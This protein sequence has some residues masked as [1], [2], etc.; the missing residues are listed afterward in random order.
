M[1]LELETGPF[2]FAELAKLAAAPLRVDKVA[3]RT[4]GSEKTVSKVGL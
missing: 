4:P 3:L 2:G 1:E